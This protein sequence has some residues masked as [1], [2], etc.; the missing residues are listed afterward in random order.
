MYFETPPNRKE[1]GSAIAAPR[2]YD[3]AMVTSR[4]PVVV[5]IPLMTPAMLLAVVTLAANAKVDQ[6]P[7]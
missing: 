3:T 4:M 1:R 7:G 6:T 2:V 5:I